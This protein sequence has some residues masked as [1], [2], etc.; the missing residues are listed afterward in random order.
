MMVVVV[1]SK[2]RHDHGLRVELLP[3]SAKKQKSIT[4]TTAQDTYCCTTK[5]EHH[6]LT[7]IV[8]LCTK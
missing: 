3:T 6:V 2:G 5:Q 8:T 7:P 4:T 1:G